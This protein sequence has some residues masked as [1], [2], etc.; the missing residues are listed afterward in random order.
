MLYSKKYLSEDHEL[1]IWERMMMKL[2]FFLK[3]ISLSEE[4]GF[5]LDPSNVKVE[6]FPLIVAPPKSIQLTRMS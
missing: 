2:H 4:K 1:P 3:D 5:G 6:K